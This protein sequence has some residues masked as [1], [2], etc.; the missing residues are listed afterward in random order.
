[1]RFAQYLQP[2]SSLFRPIFHRLK[3]GEKQPFFGSHP[4]NSG[5]NPLGGAMHQ[6]PDALRG[7]DTV[8]G[9]AMLRQPTAGRLSG[10]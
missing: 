6:S 4:G 9:A 10:A 1:M 7:R 8:H 3:K 5:S 2:H